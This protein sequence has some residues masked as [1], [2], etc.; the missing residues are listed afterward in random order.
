MGLKDL[1]EKIPAV[2]KMNWDN[3]LIPYITKRLP[4]WRGIPLTGTI[5]Q[6]RQY[7]NFLINKKIFHEFVIMR[8]CPWP[9]DLAW[10][11]EQILAAGDAVPENK[12]QMTDVMYLYKNFENIMKKNPC[13]KNPNKK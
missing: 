5:E 10:G 9:K 4:E 11:F 3:G 6:N 13:K 8:K 1:L 12:E 7:S 2:Q